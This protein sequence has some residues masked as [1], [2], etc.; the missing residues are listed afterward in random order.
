MSCSYLK[1]IVPSEI[2]GVEGVLCVVSF[3]HY[4]QEILMHKVVILTN[5]KV[6]SKTTN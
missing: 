2:G 6:Q 5:N 3:F 1:Y 4:F